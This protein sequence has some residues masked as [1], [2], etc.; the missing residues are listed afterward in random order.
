RLAG[1]G[2]SALVAVLPAQPAEGPVRDPCHR[3]QDDRGVDGVAPD[4]QRREQRPGADGRGDGRR[5]DDGEAGG[6]ERHDPTIVPRS[7][8]SPALSASATVEA[9]GTTTYPVPH[10]H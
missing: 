10:A 4:L 6:G 9:A 1:G 2:G 8:R 7:V 5:G 3:R